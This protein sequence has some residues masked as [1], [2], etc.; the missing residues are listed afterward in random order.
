MDQSLDG[1]DFRPFVFLPRDEFSL[2]RPSTPS[3][4]DSRNH[5][6]GSRK[7][8]ESHPRKRQREEREA[9]RA[10]QIKSASP[11]A[12]TEIVDFVAPDKRPQITAHRLELAR[13]L[14]VTLERGPIAESDHHPEIE[15]AI[16]SR[17]QRG[18][19]P[20]SL[21]LQHARHHSQ[22][23]CG[24]P[25]LGAIRTAIRVFHPNQD[26]VGHGRRRCRQRA[27]TRQNKGTSPASRPPRGG[28]DCLS[29][30]ISLP[31]LIQEFRANWRVR[32]HFRTADE[33]QTGR[34]AA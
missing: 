8:A 28:R 15:A 29:Q 25:E 22:G 31:S 34:K 17:R 6:S 16:E 21:H 9:R 14:F 32:E 7:A 13:I 24:P 26:H 2:L 30:T 3:P 20:A 27:A 11:L 10:L 19:G 33:R 18:N 4:P 1:P 5:S 23:I 12:T